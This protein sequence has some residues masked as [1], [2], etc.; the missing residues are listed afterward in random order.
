MAVAGDKD[1][2]VPQA[3]TSPAPPRPAAGRLSRIGR[4]PGPGPGPGL[5]AVPAPAAA[6]A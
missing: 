4:L 2:G 6:P 1:V 3:G 5:R